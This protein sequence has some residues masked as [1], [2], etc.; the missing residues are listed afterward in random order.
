MARTMELPSMFAMLRLTLF[1][2]VFGT[3]TAFK[4]EVIGESQSTGVFSGTVNKGP[5]VPAVRP[6]LGQPPSGVAGAQVDIANSAE[7]PVE[8]VKTDSTGAFRVNLPAGTYKVT[9][10]SLYGAMFTK[11]LPATV[12]IVAGQ[13]TRLDIHLDTGMR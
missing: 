5:V 3:Q 11:D 8:S 12:T 4:S 13:Q 1:L 10:P 9:M 6:G 2:V 7:K